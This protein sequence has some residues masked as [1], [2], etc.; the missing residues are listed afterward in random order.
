MWPASRGMRGKG[1][2]R[3]NGISGDDGLAGIGTLGEALR[4]SLLEAYHKPLPVH[5]SG[6]LMFALLMIG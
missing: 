3:D 6:L 4:R 2:P 1:Q 5:A